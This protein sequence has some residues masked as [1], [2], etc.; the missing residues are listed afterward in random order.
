MKSRNALLFEA[1]RVAVACAILL[2]S[3]ALADLG[4][5]MTGAPNPARAGGSLTYRVAITNSGSGTALNAVVTDVLPAGL[6]FASCT[7]SQGSFANDAGTI[8]CNLGNL[9]PGGTAA[10]TIVTTPTA[11]GA[12]TNQASV[13]ADNAAGGRV[14]VE[15]AV[16]AAN[17]APEI[18]LPGPHTVLLGASTGFV[19]SV[20][21]PDHDPV[22]TLTN[23]FKPAGATFNGA[24]FAW[25]ATRAAWNT[26]N[27]IEF[28]ADDHQGEA[29][30][31]VTNRVA[32]VVPYDGDSD[33]MDDGWE[34]DHFQKLT[35]GPAGDV[36]DDGM[37]NGDEYTTGT[38]PTN[39]SSA[40]VVMSVV[41]TSGGGSHQ[42][43]VA[44]EPGRKY[45]IYW[46][47]SNPPRADAWAPFAVPAYGVWVENRA[48]STNYVFTDNEG[49]G[50]T[51]GPPASGRRF[52]R[53]KAERQ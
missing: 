44:T 4:I 51:G 34:W 48:V 14:T 32:L 53:V 36:D 27:W 49:A 8:F 1:A 41:S 13:S 16:L 19:V 28:V 15:T 29:N 9:G 20:T 42:V 10:V 6:Q 38:Q 11:V 24:Q 26:T 30:S 25:T 12:V 7:V 33:G 5:S 3:V 23:T 40:F 50:T 35:N 47:D 21:D 18:A 46:Q 45:T 17:R 2:P 22:V 31:V 43:R 52:Y 37:S 39:R